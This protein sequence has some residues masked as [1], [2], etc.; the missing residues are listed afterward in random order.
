MISILIVFLLEHARDFKL[1]S[2]K[3]QH[4]KNAVKDKHALDLGK[5]PLAAGLVCHGT[6]T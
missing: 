1:Q 4:G 2:F 3:I 6:P 5:D